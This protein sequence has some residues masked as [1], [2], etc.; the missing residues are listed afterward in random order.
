MSYSVKAKGISRDLLGEM[1]VALAT[2][3]LFAS[4][5]MAGVDYLMDNEDQIRSHLV[6]N[7][8]DWR[9]RVEMAADA[10]KVRI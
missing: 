1:P 7:L 4:S 5:L 9:E 10:I 8:P 2:P 6:A 3:Q